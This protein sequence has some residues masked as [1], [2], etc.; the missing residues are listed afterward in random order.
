MASAYITARDI[1][2]M[3]ERW[4]AMD[5]IDFAVPHEVQMQMLVDLVRLMRRS[6]R[7]LLRNR[8][9]D[10]DPAGTR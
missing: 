1:F 2:G 8:R 9:A 4:Q 3:E 5:D 7:W 6:A 10:L